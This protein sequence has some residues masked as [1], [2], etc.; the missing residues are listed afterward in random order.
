MTHKNHTYHFV[1][2]Q[3]YTI[4]EKSQQY[5]TLFTKNILRRP[6]NNL[7][8]TKHLCSASLVN[9]TIYLN[10]S[11]LR[12]LDFKL[13]LCIDI[14]PGNKKIKSHKKNVSLFSN[15]LDNLPVVFSAVQFC[16]LSNY[17]GY[18]QNKADIN[19][20]LLQRDKWR[21]LV[22]LWGTFPALFI[23]NHY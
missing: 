3:N 12:F 15:S 9:D 13:I 7:I 6:A 19:M 22:V 8:F 11:G 1:N 21:V 5:Y 23:C 20:R 16:R 14:T 4:T 10:T 17:I 18:G 2:K